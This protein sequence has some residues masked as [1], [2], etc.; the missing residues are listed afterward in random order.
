MNKL[1][2]QLFFL[3]AGTIANAQDFT[4]RNINN[5]RI[6]VDV[7]EVGDPSANNH[8]FGKKN[9]A[10]TE[11]K[12]LPSTQVS[13]LRGVFSISSYPIIG[14]V[15][16]TGFSDMFNMAGLKS[17]KLIDARFD[18]YKVGFSPVGYAL[19]KKGYNALGLQID[20]TPADWLRLKFM[21]NGFGAD[22]GSR[23]QLTIVL[24]KFWFSNS[25]QDRYTAANPKLTTTLHYHFDIYTSLDI[26]YYP[27]RKFAGTLTALYNNGDA[28]NGLADSL[29][30]LLKKEVFTNIYSAKETETNWL[31]PVD[32]N[33]YYNKRFKI[34][35]HPEKK[36]RGVYETYDDFLANKPISDSVEMI[37][38]YNNYERAVTYAC[39][40]TAFKD[41]QPVSCNK[42]WGYYDGRALF[43]NT[44][45]GI[46]IKLIRTKEDFVFYYLKNFNEEKIN[47]DLQASIIIGNA[48]YQVLKDYKKAFGLTYQ[49]DYETGKLY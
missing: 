10:L 1:F 8:S 19:Q 20:K 45:H 39:Q 13:T 25:A 24:Q 36:P 27:Q 33:D 47:P 49:L 12:N 18:N 35:A 15:P 21:Q 43:V 34:L 38:K 22:T 2:F 9:D 17:I 46:F 16:K 40:L 23:R 5:T 28:Y 37:V 44:G 31:S 32:F 41:G 7:R 26:G 48:S 42:S 6:E 29:L 4:P 14:F 30:V 11:L 3:L